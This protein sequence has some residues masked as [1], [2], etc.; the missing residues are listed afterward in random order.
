M[1]DEVFVSSSVNLNFKKIK[2]LTLDSSHKNFGTGYPETDNFENVFLQDGG[3]FFELKQTSEKQV[4]HAF[5][6]Q[7]SYLLQLIREEE[8]EKVEKQA[9]NQRLLREHNAGDLG[10]IHEKQQT[11]SWL[12]ISNFN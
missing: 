10:P 3:R 5:S 1:S 4:N 2:L 12:E 6:K 9:E 11:H 8:D 7:D